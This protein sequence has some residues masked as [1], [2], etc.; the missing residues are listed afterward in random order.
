MD[1]IVI[2][3]W[4]DIWKHWPLQVRTLIILVLC[5]P[6]TM[7]KQLSSQLF[8]IY[9]WYRRVFANSV[10]GLD[11]NQMPPSSVD[12]NSSHQVLEER[13]I[14]STPFVVNNQLIHQESVIVNLQHITSNPVL[15]LPK[16]TLWFQLSWGDL[17]AMPLINGY[18]EVHP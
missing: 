16:P 5:I 15:L 11:T 17:I 8:Q 6:P 3:K 13:W 9:V 14:N 1:S 7:I 4:L 18:F 10:E 2:C 12:L